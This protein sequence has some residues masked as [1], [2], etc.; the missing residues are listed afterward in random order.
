[1]IDRGIGMF[2]LQDSVS[3]YLFS[4]T[5]FFCSEHAT[6]G[7]A[8]GVEMVLGM[9]SDAQVPFSGDENAVVQLVRCAR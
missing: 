9:T 6:E 1:M 5:W 4:Y 7:G 3:W 8:G 2:C